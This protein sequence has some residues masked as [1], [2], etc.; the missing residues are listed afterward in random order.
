MSARRLTRSLIHA[1]TEAGE[2]AVNSA[3]T[4]AARLPIFAGC[5]VAPTAEGVAEWNRAC[6]EKATAAWQGLFAASAAWQQVMIRAAFCPPSPAALAN[7][8]VRV[9]H[10]AGHAARKAVK[11]NARRLGPARK[12]G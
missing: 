4:I 6:A 3:V 7:D 11:A 5:L 9:S 8:L 12:S 1:G 10:K 2:A